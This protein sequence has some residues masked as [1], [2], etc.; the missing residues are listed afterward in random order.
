MKYFGHRDHG[1]ARH[2]HTRHGN[3]RHV[4]ARH[5]LARHGHARHGHARH[6]LTV[7][8]TCV[9][10]VPV[11][12][13][14]TSRTIVCCESCE[15]HVYVL[16]FCVVCM[17]AMSW[18]VAFTVFTKFIRI[19][20]IWIVFIFTTCSFWATWQGVHIWINFWAF[21]RGHYLF[22]MHSTHTYSYT[23]E[24]LRQYVYKVGNTRCSPYLLY[25]PGTWQIISSRRCPRACSRACRHSKNCEFLCIWVFMKLFIIENTSTH[26]PSRLWIML[27]RF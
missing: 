24:R 6:V 13:T 26:S 10:C 25:L 16:C 11:T 3:A 5:G 27:L 21:F 17:N 23:L 7:T 9:T 1:H 4:H 8:V 12:V 2:G 20:T 22:N 18:A 14:M 15:Q 19:H